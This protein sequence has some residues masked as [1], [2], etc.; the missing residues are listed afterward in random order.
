MD[1]NTRLI[2]CLWYGFVF[3]NFYIQT[4]NKNIIQSV[5]A[6]YGLALSAVG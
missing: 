2:L 5:C 1:I 3:V 6:E 4:L